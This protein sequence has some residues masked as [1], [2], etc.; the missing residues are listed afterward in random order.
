MCWYSN[1]KHKRDPRVSMTIHDFAWAQIE[2]PPLNS[3]LDTTTG[4]HTGSRSSVLLVV[5]VVVP[6][7]TL[8]LK[9]D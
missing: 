4:A 6:S 9:S 2:T 5:V 3:D 1:V 7:R 8:H